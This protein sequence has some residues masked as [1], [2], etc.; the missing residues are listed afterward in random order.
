V[1]RGNSFHP[2]CIWVRY[3]ERPSTV[4]PFLFFSFFFFF[5]SS[6]YFALRKDA[7]TGPQGTRA[8]LSLDRILFFLILSNG[9]RCSIA[10]RSG[11]P[12]GQ[13]CE[14]MQLARNFSEAEASLQHASSTFLYFQDRWTR[15]T[16]ELSSFLVCQNGWCKMNEN[17][18]DNYIKD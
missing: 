12:F 5:F 15:S 11:Q 10:Q 17:S 13:K 8:D 14:T 18:C 7:L 6:P 16:N 9:P 3:L 2:Q 4:F 1:N